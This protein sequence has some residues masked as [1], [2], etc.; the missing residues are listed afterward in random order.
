ML[1][2]VGEWNTPSDNEEEVES[3]NETKIMTPSTSERESVEKNIQNRETK[4]L[5][6]EDDTAKTDSDNWNV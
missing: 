3:S 2:D 4:F 6:G 5:S 1:F